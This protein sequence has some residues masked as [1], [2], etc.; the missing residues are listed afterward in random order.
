MTLTHFEDAVPYRPR[1][2]SRRETEAVSA[3]LA[4][5]ERARA[6]SAAEA[7]ALLRREFPSAPLEE[8]AAAI[9]HWSAG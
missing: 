8:R 4:A 2:E 5:L 1:R 3:M 6:T 7:W 9:S